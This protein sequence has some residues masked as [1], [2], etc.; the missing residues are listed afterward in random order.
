MKVCVFG[1]GVIGGILASAIGRAGHDVSVIA[2]G[3]HLEAIQAR[4][5]TVRA[6]GRLE[7][8]RPLAVADSAELSPQDLVIVATKTPS[9]PQVAEKI[10]PLISEKT[11]VAF[12][13]NGIFWFYGDGFTPGGNALDLSRLDPGGALHA[14]VPPAQALGIVCISGGEIREPG[15]VEASRMDGRFIIGAALEPARQAAANVVTQVR[16]RDIDLSWS[17]DI[18]VDMWRKYLSVVGN[19][20]TCALTGAP[21]SA[22][23]ADAGVQAVQLGLAAEAHALAKAHGFTDLGFDVEAARANP[24]RSNHKPS[25]LQDLERGRIME[26]DSAYFALQDLARQA[27]IPTPTLDIV[28]PLLALRARM[29]GCY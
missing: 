14:A 21:I 6:P 7:V 18:R 10:R 12:A 26:V 24:S 3:E 13:V 16:P 25:M 1:A 28:A 2:R 27:G 22:V 29:S 20:A 23:H 5:L 9:L 8:T 19:F 15:V 11:F 17:D 4:G